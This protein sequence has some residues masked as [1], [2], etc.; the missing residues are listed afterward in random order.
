MKKYFSPNH[1]PMIEGELFNWEDH[2]DSH[3]GERR[4][5]YV[6]L[7]GSLYNMRQC[8]YFPAT[9]LLTINNLTGETGVQPFA[10]DTYQEAELIIDKLHKGLNAEVLPLYKKV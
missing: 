10:C 5:Y 3:K 7:V 9:K 8:L 4:T 1:V 6:I 2:E